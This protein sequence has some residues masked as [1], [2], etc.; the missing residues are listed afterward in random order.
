MSNIDNEIL[1]FGQHGDN[2]DVQLRV[3]G[4]EFYARYETLA[5]YTVVYDKAEGRYCYA[6][7][8]QG[9]F[10]STGVPTSAAPPAEIPRHLKEH[11][12]VRNQKFDLR[13]QQLRP[14]ETDAD[15]DGRMLTFGANNGL[16]RGRRISTQPEVKGLTIIVEFQDIHTDVTRQQVDDM[17]NQPDYS[18]FGNFCSVFKYYDMMSNGA[19]KYTNDVVG[20]IRLSRRRSHYIDNLLVHEALNL[21]IDQ[22][23]INLADYDSKGENIVDALSILYAGRTQYNGDLW[24]HNHVTFFQQGNTRTHYYTIQS[25]G[26]N[27]TDLSIGTF[28]HESGHMLCRWPDLYDYGKRDGDN[29]KSRGMGRFCLMSSGNHLGRGKVP[30][31]VCAY[32]RNLAGWCQEVSL[33]TEGEITVDHGDYGKVY[34]YDTE[35]PNEYFLVENRAQLGLDRFLPDGGLAVYHCDIMGSN[36]LQQGTAS[37]H[38]QCA[39]LQ[40]DSS[41]HLELDQNPG[42][43]GDLFPATDGVALSSETRPNS[44]TWQGT[45]SG[46]VISDI[47]DPGPQISFSVGAS[48]SNLWFGE[49]RPHAMIPDAGEP[50]GSQGITQL[51]D[52]P[53]RGVLR[54]LLVQVDITHTYR[55][56]LGIQLIAPDGTAAMLK[57]RQQDSSD[58]VHMIVSPNDNAA[59]RGL[60]NKEIQGPWRLA[61]VDHW[62][63]DRG[64]LDYWSLTLEYE[65]TAQTIRGENQTGMDIPDDSVQG[66]SSAIPV[67]S[68]A[69]LSDLA[70]E[71]NIVHTYRGDLELDLRAPNGVII[72]LKTRSFDSSANLQ[73]TYTIANTTALEVLKNQPIDGVWHLD[74][75]DVVFRDVGRLLRW[76]I[77]IET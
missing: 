48:A 40:A 70:V 21:A 42:D 45:D 13:Y 75:R 25:L 32:L 44:Q 61:I 66:I 12:V 1:I 49:D 41:F 29:E 39:L 74:V 58:D 51:L 9:E 77:K 64:R 69:A 43:D 59:L 50:G 30:S 14:P 76:A 46:L 65:S 73:A 31:P 68:S 24:P 8:E 18:E 56:D 33:N 23:G 10:V 53:V 34:R 28:A 36:E 16:L 3:Y 52:V 55:G 22:F 17:L 26:R 67:N 37:S 47:T 20:P 57:E 4:D 71:V 15:D 11:A 38:Y 2:P 62:Q 54:D 27:T 6:R 35:A 72:P 19:L 5:G 60:V 63:E 7:L